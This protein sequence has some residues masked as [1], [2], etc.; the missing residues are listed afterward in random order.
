MGELGISVEGSCQHGVG[1]ALSCPMALLWLIGGAS[2]AK[3]FA[4]QWGL[5][6]KG[7]ILP[8][9]WRRPEAI[10]MPG[11]AAKQTC[12]KAKKGVIAKAKVHLVKASRCG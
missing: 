9:A 11:G 7:C 1:G 4:P 2:N 8:A 5:L 10:Y 3:D 12:G 6:E